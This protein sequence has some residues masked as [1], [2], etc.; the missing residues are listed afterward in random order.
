MKHFFL[1]IG[2]VFSI[3]FSNA[4]TQSS[5]VVPMNLYNAY[6]NEVY[7]IAVERLYQIQHPDT[8]LIQIPQIHRDSIWEAMA[9]VFNLGTQLSADTVF[10]HHCIHDIYQYVNAQ[11][12]I[13]IDTNIN[14]TLS[15][16][17]LTTTTGIPSLD[18]LMATYGYSP[19][20]TL[21]IGNTHWVVLGTTQ[22]LNIK[23]FCKE[24]DLYNGILNADAD[25]LLMD[26]NRILYST[27]GPNRLLKFVL[28]YFDCLSG[29][30]NHHYFNY[31]I[32]SS[33]QVSYLPIGPNSWLFYPTLQNCGLSPSN[34]TGF[35]HFKENTDL[36]IYPNPSSGSIH[37]DGLI[38]S[39]YYW[40]ISN[41]MGEIV[42]K[43]YTQFSSSGQSIDVTDL[44]NG[45]Y[46]LVINNQHLKFVK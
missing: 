27:N 44:D 29:C 3:L 19:I 12:V 34:P 25:M 21:K 43:G 5:C 20:D 33:F 11:I 23:A 14:W 13:Q 26:G 15:W 39:K 7:Y 22:R 37:I 46:V 10:A 18:T 40:Y 36:K 17:N 35:H 6:E 30:I 24:L 42:K 8:A 1:I 45:V 4:Q 16:W 38:P 41:E 28:G 9:A 32:N 31:T 2:L